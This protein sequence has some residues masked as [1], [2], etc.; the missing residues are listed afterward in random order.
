[1]AARVL[2][3]ASGMVRSKTASPEQ[4]LRDLEMRGR[5]MVSS[6]IDVLD[7]TVRVHEV[8]LVIEQLERELRDALAQQG[9]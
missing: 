9:A 1:V 8:E 5:C 6:D 4:A 3:E 7:L 2:P